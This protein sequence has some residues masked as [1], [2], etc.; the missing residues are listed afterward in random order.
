MHL[1]HVGPLFDER[2][3]IMQGKTV[4]GAFD[5]PDDGEPGENAL[6]AQA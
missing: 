6:L 2:K 3:D 5:I 4:V 1:C